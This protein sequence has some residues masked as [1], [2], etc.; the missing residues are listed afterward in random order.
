MKVTDLRD[1]LL[2]VTE[3]VYHYRA[4]ARD[5]GSRYIVW[6]ETNGSVALSADDAPETLT[7]GGEIILYT[8]TEYD[9]TVNTLME[10]LADLAE[11]DVFAWQI[12]GMGYDETGHF[13][14][15]VFSWSMSCSIGGIY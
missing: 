15:Y 2:D 1:A 13:F 4:P 11:E 14:Q 12:A 6:G 7:V 10:A 9:T 5:C 3:K 8:Q